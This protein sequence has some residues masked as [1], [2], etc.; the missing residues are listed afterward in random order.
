MRIFSTPPTKTTSA[1][2]DSVAKTPA[3]K[4]VPEEVQADSVRVAAT[5]VSPAQ[6]AT[7]APICP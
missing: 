6:S 7:V 2:P 4:A 3:R 5:P 1:N